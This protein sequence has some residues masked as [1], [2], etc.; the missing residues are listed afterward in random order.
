[1]IL[2]QI[3]EITTADSIMGE[4]TVILTKHFLNTKK[5]PHLASEHLYFSH[6]S[7]YY[8]NLWSSMVPNGPIQSFLSPYW[9]VCMDLYG[10]ALSHMV[11]FGPV[12]SCM[13]LYGRMYCM[14]TFLF[15]SNTIKTIKVFDSFDFLIDTSLVGPTAL[16]HRLQ[17]HTL[18]AKSIIATRGSQN[19]PRDLDRQKVYPQVFGCSHQLSL[20]KFFDPRSCCV[21][22]GSNGEVVKNRTVKIVVHEHCCQF[23]F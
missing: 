4:S 14:G 7:F 2:P 5:I 19:G 18:P 6:V 11:L 9:P 15:K 21:R 1:M 3:Y 20:N 8:G 13:V 10:P 16:D 12:G 17:C 22:K 23:T